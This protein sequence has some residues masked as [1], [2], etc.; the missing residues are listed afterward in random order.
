[1]LPD[2]NELPVSTYQAKKLMCPMGMEIER[3]H[4][5][6]NDCMLYRNDN[7]DLHSCIT[8]G[9]SRYKR[10]NPTKENNNMR[11]SGPPAK[12]LWY[13]PIIP[14]L[15]RLFANA[16]D[17]KL[18]RWHAEERTID[19]KIRHVADSPQWR[20]INSKFEEF[21]VTSIGIPK[22][23]HEGRLVGYG[24]IGL[25]WVTPNKEDLH[26]AHFTVLQ[27]MTIIAP[28][29]NEH[30]RYIEMSNS[31]KSKRWL[32]TEHNKTF[33]QWLKDKVKASYG[34]NNVDQAVVHL[35]NGPEHV[36]ATYQAYD[37]NGYTFY[38]NQQDKKST[39]QNSGVTLET[40]L[41]SEPFPMIVAKHLE[42]S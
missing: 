27:H 11:M 33:S 42:S 18:M 25:K 29:V 26:L 35:A 20:N 8:C 6:P 41:T 32:I 24:M 9:T 15:K 22:S 36:V 34:V 30:K 31:G 23:R 2:D 10:K 13:L 37:I 28:Y 14:R 16:K 1:M 17:A 12:V 4:A 21:G 19:D 3:I 7:A 40:L 39:L 38:T 5:C